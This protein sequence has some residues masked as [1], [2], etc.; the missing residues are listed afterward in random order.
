MKFDGVVGNAVPFQVVNITNGGTGTLSGLSTG[1]VTYGG[2][3]S[4]WLTPSLNS[5]AAP[6]TLSLSVNTASMSAGTY[7]ASVPVASSAPGVTNS[8]QTVSVTVSMG[9][10]KPTI[11]LNPNTAA[12]SAVAGGADPPTQSI[13]QVYNT[14][15]GGN[16]NG[17]S[18]GTIT[19]GAGAAG[20][21]Q[22]SLSSSDA[23]TKL[24]LH[25]ST[26][27]LAAG[28]Y[29]ATVPVASSATGV[30]NSPQSVEVTFYVRPPAPTLTGISPNPVS[31]SNSDQTLVL[32]GSN[33]VP[34]ATVPL[35]TN[36]NT[37]TLSGTQVN[38]VNSGRINI[39]ATVGMQAASWTAQVVNPDGAA[40]AEL[41]FQ[42]VTPCTSG[43]AYA[44]KNWP[45][46]STMQRGQLFN[47]LFSGQ[48]TGSCTWDS[49]YNLRYVSNTAG[50][51]SISQTNIPVSGSVA[52]AAY[53][54]FDVPM[55]APNAP[56]T[57]KET[58]ALY[59]NKGTR[60]VDFWI[61]IIVQ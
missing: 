59:D 37:Y 22:A 47:L 19:Y 24:N 7:T 8:P 54:T 6:A 17:L 41:A 4:G 15:T 43:A 46:N 61:Q 16:L 39:L 29:S 31:G 13:I 12:F 35:R 32:T 56:G 5:T 42:V 40:S 18:V 1:S 3:L 14:G 26:G 53:Y 45:D 57:Y 50:L 36:G 48:N 49:S 11:T 33:F 55:R 21:L 60:R 58:W 44:S 52:P 9:A 34:G 20:W 28:T 25:A 51:L 23:P 30:T 2:S 38:V 10:G 27:S